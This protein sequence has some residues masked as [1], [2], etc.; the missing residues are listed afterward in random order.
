MDTVRKFLMNHQAIKQIFVFGSQ[1]DGTAHQDSDLDLCIIADLQHK[2]KIEMMQELRRELMSI[3][4]FPLDILVYS[5]AE[6]LER[7]QISSSLEH[8]IRY[9]GTKVYG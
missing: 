8:K 6:F 1:S 7:S 3:I 2:R 9:S 4:T 5:E